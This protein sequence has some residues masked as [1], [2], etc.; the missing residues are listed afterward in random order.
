ML[1]RDLWWNLWNYT[2]VFYEFTW[3]CFCLYFIFCI[4]NKTELQKFEPIWW[5]LLCSMIYAPVHSIFLF[6]FISTLVAAHVK[7][8]S[9]WVDATD[10][11]LTCEL[12]SLKIFKQ[13]INDY[14]FS[15]RVV[16]CMLTYFL[17]VSIVNC[18]FFKN[19]QYSCLDLHLEVFSKEICCVT[20][21]FQYLRME[22]W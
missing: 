11:C 3:L 21:L 12:D 1:Q 19:L 13:M 17:G 9:F 20:F 15:K 6:H 14:V 22:S 16:K 10:C 7:P 8:I 2:C 4:S 18:F 5:F